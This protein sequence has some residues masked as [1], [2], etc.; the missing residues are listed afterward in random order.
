MKKFCYLF[1]LFL[2]LLFAGGFHAS[3]FDADRLSSIVG[4]NV[5]ATSD[6]FELLMTLMQIEELYPDFESRKTFLRKTGIIP[7][8]WLSKNPADP[9]TQGDLAYALVKTLR[10]HG[11][12]KARLF[13]MNKRFALEEL[14]YQGVMSPVHSRDY[15]TGEELVAIMTQ[16]L[17]LMAERR[18][19]DVR[20]E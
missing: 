10:L 11:G 18:G 15:V 19:G 16:A 3:A 6:A 2:Y 1:P 5:A 14:I 12:L 4:R 20:G 8:S 9:L 17:N 7:S 13:G